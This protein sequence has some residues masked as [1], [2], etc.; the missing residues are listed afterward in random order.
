MYWPND[1]ELYKYVAAQLGHLLVAFLYEITALLDIFDLPGSPDFEAG[2]R[3]G[4]E[5]A[6]HPGH[7]AG[8]ALLGLRHLHS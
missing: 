4:S 3:D 7:A 1:C 2:Q 6:H 5:P 8:E